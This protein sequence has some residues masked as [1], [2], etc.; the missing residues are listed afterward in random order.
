VTTE[1]EV[2]DSQCD[3]MR[4]FNFPNEFTVNKEIILEGRDYTYSYLWKFRYRSIFL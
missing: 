2:Q 3:T 4:V 1:P